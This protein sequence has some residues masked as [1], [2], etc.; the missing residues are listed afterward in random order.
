LKRLTQN[1]AFLEACLRE[2]L[3]FSRL[4]LLNAGILESLPPWMEPPSRL[5]MLKNLPSLRLAFFTA[6]LLK[7]LP[8]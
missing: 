3:H 6:R 2:G 7:G 8:S 1:N 4:A 5:T